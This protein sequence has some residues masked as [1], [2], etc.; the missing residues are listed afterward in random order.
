MWKV[1]SNIKYINSEGVTKELNAKKGD[2]DLQS[3]N[4][5]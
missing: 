4:H 1:D 5:S 3:N 2:D